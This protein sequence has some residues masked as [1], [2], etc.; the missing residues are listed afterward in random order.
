MSS[1]SNKVFIARLLGLDVFDPLGDRLGRL[2]DVVVFDRGP[3]RPAQCVGIVVE[4]PGRKRVFVPMTRIQAMEPSQIICSGL[5][6]LRRFQQ[7]G[8][9]SLAAAELFDRR[10][11]FKDGSGNGVVED[12]GLERQRNGDWTVAEYFVRRGE[13]GGFRALRRLAR[14]ER[15]LVRWDE[16]VRGQTQ[17]PQAATQFVAANEELKPA[18]FAEALHEMSDKRRVEV[19]TE[20]QDD[21][22]ADVLPEL[23]DDEQVQILS[24]L[25][26][27]RAADVLEEMDPDD[28]ADLLAELSHEQQEALL[29]LMEP[30]EAND[31]RRLLEYEENTAGSMM[32]PVPVILPPEATVAEA[33]ASVRR[34]ELSPALAST[35]FV[36]RPPL[37]TPTGRY[38][39][40]VH[41]QALLRCAPPEAL[42][43]ILD[44]DLEPVSDLADISEVSRRLATYNLTSLPVVNHAGRLVGA[45][46]VDDVLDHLLPED[47]R[48]HDGDDKLTG[49]RA[50]G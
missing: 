40:V 39:G 6:N 20:L 16:V 14:G 48:T 1:S 13:P 17:E 29:E 32:T 42:G 50:H 10:V 9:E 21:R 46:T 43:S 37:E 44:S 26:M 22:L 36:C 35:V 24:S 12:I 18:D 23:P 31:V 28:A 15:V 49:G 19:A 4:V 3:S 25:D 38:L 47:W 2:R 11:S 27:E 7:R 41:I 33:L 8:A 30:D 45:V 5:V 34:E